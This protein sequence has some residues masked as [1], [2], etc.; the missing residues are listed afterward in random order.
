[1]ASGSSIRPEPG[2]LAETGS[3]TASPASRRSMAGRQKAAPSPQQQRHSVL[4]PAGLE[5]PGLGVADLPR[6]TGELWVPDDQPGPSD[7]W[8][9]N[10]GS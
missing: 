2:F 8:G 7:P 9:L 10:R 3:Y 5:A 4:L 6:L 1:M